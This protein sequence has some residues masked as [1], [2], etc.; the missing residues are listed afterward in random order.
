MNRRKFLIGSGAL[1]LSASALGRAAYGQTAWPD[2]Y[3]SDY[4]DLVKAG[5]AEGKV[6]VYQ[7]TSA[8]DP[9]IQAFNKLYPEIKVETVNLGSSEVVERYLA[10][11]GSKSPTCDVTISS[12]PDSY[13]R[14]LD[15]SELV[16]YESPETPKMPD[17]VHPAPGLYTCLSEPQVV[18]YNKALL[19]PELVPTGFADLVAKAQAH[20]EVF[21][22][23]MTTYGAHFGSIGYCSAFKTVDYHGEKAWE[24]LKILGPMTKVERSAGPQMEKTTLGEYV[25]GY[26]SGWGTPV[27]ASRDPDRSKVFAWKLLD[28]GQVF[29]PYGISVLR[30][31]K[32]PNAG[33]LFLD[34]VL[35]HQGQLGWLPGDRVSVRGDITD[36]ERGEHWTYNSL[37]AL[38]GESNVLRLD[39]DPKLVSGYDD[40][41]AKW[42]AAYRV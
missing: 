14:L 37:A 30:G 28:D 29:L 27:A 18:I 16:A 32:N 10:E 20:P 19:P 11:A 22:G 41:I 7:N 25:L 34:L 17:W 13:L 15:R 26:N 24:W 23:K 1:G 33:K 21:N 8:M 42:R 6:V 31:G 4:A 40:F 3:P 38:V 39:Y 9:L 12:A 35:S 36:A 2:Y 5:T